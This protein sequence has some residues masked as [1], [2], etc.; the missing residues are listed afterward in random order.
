[1][2]TKKFAW[3]TY[4]SLEDVIDVLRLATGI[5]SPGALVTFAAL[6]LA[7]N[8]R[9]IKPESR[10]FLQRKIDTLARDISEDPAADRIIKELAKKVSA[11]N[12]I[13]EVYGPYALQP[14]GDGGWELIKASEQE[15]KGQRGTVRRIIKPLMFSTFEQALREA[16][17]YLGETLEPEKRDFDSAAEFHA[18]LDHLGM[19]EV[20]VEAAEGWAPVGVGE[21]ADGANGYETCEVCGE[22]SFHQHSSEL[23]VYWSGHCHLCGFYRSDVEA[24][25]MDAEAAFRRAVERDD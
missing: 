14:K 25:E 7:S 24:G 5:K 12:Q 3:Y 23:G 22:N 21:I 4:S 19:W 20:H 15:H 16:V 2:G 8:E 10:D 17:R 6:L 18:A 1:M 9:Y 13:S 11:A